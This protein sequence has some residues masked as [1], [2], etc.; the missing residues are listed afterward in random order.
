VTVADSGRKVIFRPGGVR[1]SSAGIRGI[2]PSPPPVRSPGGG[3]GGGRGIGQGPGGGRGHGRGGGNSLAALALAL[4]AVSATGG[5]VV[6]SSRVGLAWYTGTGAPA[7]TL[8]ALNEFYYDQAGTRD[9][10]QKALSGASPGFRSAQS[11]GALS[12]VSCAAALPTGVTVGDLLVACVSSQQSSAIV[13][14]S[15]PAGWTLQ[16]ATTGR[17]SGSGSTAV[18]TKIADGTEGATVTFSTTGQTTTAFVAVVAAFFSSS[19]DQIATGALT[20]S[21]SIPGPSVTPS[22]AGDLILQILMGLTGGGGSI[23]T[24]TPPAGFSNLIDGR[25]AS[26]GGC[27][28]IS[29]KLLVGGSGSPTGTFTTTLG[30]SES[31][32][33]T[34]LAIKPGTQT[35]NWARVGSLAA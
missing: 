1:V 10:Y 17:F 22:A 33:A 20:S 29:S 6:P 28:E 9:V 8:G 18:F 27:I 4:G 26:T 12:S 16:A 31:W 32:F 14:I 13:A 21:T 34:T 23:P 11:T 2:V 15:T 5:K 7:N 35:P 25:P 3:Q 24:V 30:T 19:F